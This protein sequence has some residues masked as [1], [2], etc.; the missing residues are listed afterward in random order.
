MSDELTCKEL[1]ELVTSYLE[2]ALSAEERARVE[3]HLAT[4]D[5]CDRYVEQ[6]RQTIE[7][8]GALRETDLS[9]EAQTKLLAAFRHWRGSQQ[10]A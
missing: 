6:M 4:C 8:L 2:N 10:N 1:V 3:A 7:S 5:G 9:P